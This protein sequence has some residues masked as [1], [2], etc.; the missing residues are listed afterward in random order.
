MEENS[1]ESG[2]IGGV[3]DRGEVGTLTGLDH[4][5]AAERCCFMRVVAMVPKIQFRIDSE[6]V[7]IVAISSVPFRNFIIVEEL[8]L[9]VL[10]MNIQKLCDHLR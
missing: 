8:V 4:G 6:P 9:V 1:L 3:G 5:L 2:S 7:L 10:E